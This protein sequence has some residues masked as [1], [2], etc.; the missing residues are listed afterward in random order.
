M[1][2]TYSPPGRTRVSEGKIPAPLKGMQEDALAAAMRGI[3]AAERA[4]LP[5]TVPKDGGFRSHKEQ[6]RLK[7]DQERHPE[8]YP[9]NIA[10]PGESMHELGTALDVTHGGGSLP[11]QQ[12]LAQIMAPHGWE[13]AGPADPVHFN[14]TGQ[15]AAVGDPPASLLDAPLPAAT[16]ATTSSGGASL[17]DAPLPGP[18]LRGGAPPSAAPMTRV[19]GGPPV[20]P[21]AGGIAAPLPPLA[22]AALPVPA[23]PLAAAPPVTPAEPPLPTGAPTPQSTRRMIGVTLGTDIAAAPPAPAPPAFPRIAYRPTKEEVGLHQADRALDTLPPFAHAPGYHPAAGGPIE[24]LRGQ[25]VQAQTALAGRLPALVQGWQKDEKAIADRWQQLTDYLKQNQGGLSAEQV[26]AVK[27]ERQNLMRDSVQI[28]GRRHQL[29]Q[30]AQRLGMAAPVAA[31]PQPRHVSVQ[32][33][34][35]PE[36]RHASIVPGRISPDNFPDLPHLI[37]GGKE[38]LSALLRLGTKPDDAVNAVL[39]RIGQQIHD[40][41]ERYHRLGFAPIWSPQGRAQIRKDLHE[42]AQAAQTA[43]TSQEATPPQFL[44]N[45]LGMQAGRTNRLAYDAAGT[46]DYLLGG[47]VAPSNLIL[48]PVWEKAAVPALKY[49][50]KPIAE[51]AAK[52]GEMLAEQAPKLAQAGSTLAE[53]LGVGKG[54]GLQRALSV[55]LQ[56][57]IALRMTEAG[58]IASDAAAL[59]VKH[60]GSGAVQQLVG[61]AL[62]HDRAVNP[63]QISLSAAAQQ[64]LMGL[65]KQA[66]IPVQEA[67]GIANRLLSHANETAEILERHGGVTPGTY[68]KA[69]AARTAFLEQYAKQAFGQQAHH[70]GIE[71]VHHAALADA[72]GQAAAD[73]A[74]SAVVSATDPVKPGWVQ[75]PN[76][77]ARYG[78]L[79]GR[80]VPAAVSRFI[81]HEVSPAHVTG[82]LSSAQQALQGLQGF[83]RATARN[84]K[85]VALTGNP[86]GWIASF[87]ARGV[88][89]ELAARRAGMSTAEFLARVAALGPKASKEWAIW[90]KTGKMTPGLKE[91][92]EAMPGFLAHAGTAVGQGSA[93]FA[94]GLVSL[95]GKVHGN[96]DQLWKYTLYKALKPKVG[97]QRAAE[98][99]DQHLFNYNDRGQLLEMA[100]RYGLWPFNAFPTKAWGLFLHTLVERPD[101]VARYPRLQRMLMAEQP[102]SQQAY[103]NVPGYQ[104]SPSTLPIPGGQFANLSR[105][106]V[107]GEPLDIL[108]PKQEEASQQNPLDVLLSHTLAGPAI[109]IALNNR[110]ALTGQPIVPEGAPPGE[111]TRLKAQALWEQGKPGI[112]RAGERIAG[113]V[114]GQPTSPGRYAEPQTVPQAL[115]QGLLDVPI[116]KPEAFSAKQKRLQ[117]QQQKLQATGAAFIRQLETRPASD[118]PYLRQARGEAGKMQS[119]GAVSGRLKAVTGYIRGE[120]TKPINYSGGRLT[121]EAKRSIEHAWLFR[122]A[123]IERGR[124]LQQAR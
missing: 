63:R 118:S 9:Y 80:Q 49:L 99:V 117:P 59:D 45:V 97:A 61:E 4:G 38:T 16:P 67:T 30:Y 26:A 123:L 22:V 109:D 18:P 69:G 108:T 29:A 25:Q 70:L 122:Q 66:G 75:I 102:G 53:G 47:A 90:Q 65:A 106:T 111:A 42:Y 124:Q 107:F 101:L 71:A 103:K 76:K 11:E 62:G 78:S 20:L 73:P 7:A 85:G 57:R 84:T 60:G 96:L 56:H 1:P 48:G 52:G 33:Q 41:P 64:Q 35:E 28:E 23:S 51:L 55:P 110:S 34:A 72:L 2:A 58:E 88:A 21:P 17:I 81:E 120:I 24:R 50:G 44:R 112:I 94:E 104:Q 31:M 82:E 113:A 83:A 105:Y 93:G 39:N 8:R 32:P 95:G 40:L 43:L 68:T 6:G 13:W 37:E 3:H 54:A 79:A 92:A 89:A 119:L 12:A 77:P 14:F 27:R 100:D 121:D 5:L 19:R 91:A 15:K 114:T 116:V 46:V 10:K 87:G 98:L 115:S 74:L 86:A 36:P